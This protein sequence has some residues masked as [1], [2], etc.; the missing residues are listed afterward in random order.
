MRSP[1]VR[2]MRWTAQGVAAHAPAWAVQVTQLR[3]LAEQITFS[4]W[5][6]DP[7]KPGAE[8]PATSGAS[9]RCVSLPGV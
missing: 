4:E 5:G 6:P 3:R 9:M 8:C 7:D 1:K 2:C